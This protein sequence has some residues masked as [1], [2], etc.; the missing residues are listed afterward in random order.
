MSKT[1]KQDPKFRAARKATS[2]TCRH[3]A[4]YFGS[5]W[6]AIARDVNRGYKRLQASGTIFTVPDITR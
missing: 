2:G 3:A 6:A 4:D 5:Y 1:P